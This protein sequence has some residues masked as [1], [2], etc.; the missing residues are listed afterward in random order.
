M[1]FHSCFFLDKKLQNGI[2]LMLI[3]SCLMFKRIKIFCSCHSFILNMFVMTGYASLR[4]EVLVAT[5]HYVGLFCS[6]HATPLL[7]FFFSVVFSASMGLQTAKCLGD[8]NLWTKVE[9]V[10]HLNSQI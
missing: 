7:F 10:C 9:L 5:D 4:S 1:K 6:S 3:R 8:S 2:N